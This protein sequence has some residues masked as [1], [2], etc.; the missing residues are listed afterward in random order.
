[1]EDDRDET[2][3]KYSFTRIS[4]GFNE[5]YPCMKLYFCIKLLSNEQQFAVLRQWPERVVYD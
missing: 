4:L 5:I 2:G 1:M 3:Q